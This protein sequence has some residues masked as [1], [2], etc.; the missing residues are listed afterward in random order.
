[1][2]P[3]IFNLIWHCTPCA[4]NDVWERNVYQLLQRI[5]SFNGKRIVGVATGA[6]GMPLASLAEVKQRFNRTRIDEFVTADNCDNHFRETPTFYPMMDMVRSD[7]PDEATFRAHA[8]GVSYN[9]DSKGVTSW[10]NAMYKY[11][12]DDFGTIRRALTTHPVVGAFR[13]ANPNGDLKKFKQLTPLIQETCRWHFAGTFWWFRHD[14]LFSNPKWRDVPMDC[15]WAVEFYLPFLFNYDQTFCTFGDGIKAP[16]TNQ[17]ESLPDPPDWR[18]SMLGPVKVELGGGVNPKGDGYTNIDQRPGAD[19]VMNLQDVAKG[20]AKLP[21]E[22]DTVDAVYAAHVIEHLS[23]CIGLLHE[24]CRMCKPG[25]EVEIRVPHWLH[26]YAMADS[27]DAAFG[28]H[29]HTWGRRTVFLLCEQEQHERFWP[30]DK[31]LKLTRTHY[32]PEVHFEPFLKPIFSKLGMNDEQIFT[33]VP[34]A[35][36]EVRYNFTVTKKGA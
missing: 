28:G 14:A 9:H 18:Q 7:N 31:K 27:L 30:G 17:P 4:S 23:P 12:L 19:V 21:Y 35:C 25:A 11:L 29:R 3:R 8:K 10:R 33:F 20:D 16:Y 5:E 1:M 2:G 26:S 24:I 15:G 34:E 32:E 6:N 13:Q 22:D 36:H